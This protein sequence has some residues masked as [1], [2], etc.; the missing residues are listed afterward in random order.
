MCSYK[1]H[2]YTIIDGVVAKE[3]RKG[4]S[5]ATES[6]GSISTA[7]AN[8]QVVASQDKQ[9]RKSSKYNHYNADVHAEIAKS[10]CEKMLS[11]MD[12]IMYKTLTIWAA[13]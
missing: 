7:A 5:S 13:R 4:V 1:E 2:V 10:A 9:C 12:G 6:G 11:F 3:W 8:H